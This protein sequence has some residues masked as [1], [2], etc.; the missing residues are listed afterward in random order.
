MKGR[1]FQTVDSHADI[2]KETAL[3]IGRNPELGHE[4]FKASERLTGL[5]ENFGFEVERGTLGITTAFIARY[6]SAKPGP[7]IAFLAEFDALPELGHACGH[8]LI[9]S[10]SVAAAV[11][12]KSVIDETGGEIRVYGTPAEETKGAKVPMSAAGLFDDVDAALMAHPYHTYEHSGQSLAMDAV[13]FEYFGKP[14]HAAANP[15]EGINALDGVLQLFNSINALRQQLESHVRIHGIITEGGVAANIIPEYAAAQFY[16]RSA[17]R[18]Y[19]DQTVI[20]VR[21]CAEG[22][23]LQTGCRLVISNY[24]FS[25]DELAT[26]EI[27]SSVYTDNLTALGISGE[28]IGT[29]KDHGSVDLGNVSRRCPAIHPYLKVIEEKHLLHTAEFRDLAMTDRALA[30]MLF[31]AKVLAATAWDVLAIPG[32]KERI[33]EEFNRTVNA[34]AAGRNG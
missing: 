8:H 3:Y 23:A 21:K 19:T 22:A 9:C 17:N 6:R 18:P 31:G 7:V 11:G 5:L 4:E 27:L 25:Y 32:L 30:G 20:K 14:A 16:I 29:G 13:Q 12:L 1:I 28:S 15:A 33:R 34:A 2:F 24:E 10:M 26:N